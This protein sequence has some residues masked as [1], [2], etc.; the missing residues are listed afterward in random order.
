MPFNGSGTFNVYTPGTPY[1][2]GTTISSTVANN[3]NSDFATGLSTC[4]TKDGQTTTTAAIP[5]ASG[6]QTNTIT[7][8]TAGS[9]VT[10][11]KQL[12]TQSATVASAAT[13]NIGAAAGNYIK[14]T[15]NTSITSFG[16]VAAGALRV[17]EFNAAATLVHNA[18]SMILPGGANITAANNDTAL[19]ISEGSGNWR[20]AAYQKAS[21]A[22]VTLSPI[23]SSLSAPVAMNNTSAYFDGP[24]INQG[25]SGTWFVSGTITA[26]DTAGGANIFAKLWDGTTVIASGAITPYTAN[27]IGVIALS[28]YIANP[29]GNLRISARD[30]SSTNGVISN[31]VSVNGNFDS[32][33]TAMRIA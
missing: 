30:I 23:T 2:T 11:S 16:T 5:F 29:A 1:V 14:I 3:V 15:G 7:E 26:Y 22:P 4:I 17:I 8:L 27:A 33:I 12:N 21:G 20:V 25:T 13:A 18:T 9:G 32:T 24:S 28:G 6:I 19:A 10:V 31:N